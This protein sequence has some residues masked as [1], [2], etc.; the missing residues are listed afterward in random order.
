MASSVVEVEG[1]KNKSGPKVVARLEI[2]RAMDGGHVV[3][4]HYEGYAHEPKSYTF[5]K[6]EGA[7][8]AG[9]I[10]RHAGLPHGQATDGEAE[11]E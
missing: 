8:A 4:H 3:T 11:E 1:K 7:R 6:G 5:G 10:A 2:K 9:H